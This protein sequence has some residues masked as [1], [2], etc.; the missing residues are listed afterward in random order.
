MADKKLLLVD[1][2]PLVRR[3]LQKTLVRAGYE[4]E[5]AGSC[6]EGLQ[7][8]EAAEQAGAPFQVAVLDLN[9]PNFEGREASGAG[10]ELLSRLMALRPTLAVIMLSAYDEV[11]K[12]KEALGR[13]ARGY[14]VKGREQTLVEQIGQMVS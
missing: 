5:A 13:G 11:N 2:E 12:A 4:V 3:S 10:L 14:C 1:D 9:M 7:V 8:F 6:I